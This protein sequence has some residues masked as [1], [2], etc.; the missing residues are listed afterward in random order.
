MKTKYIFGLLIAVTGLLWGVV[1]SLPD[2]KLH[3]Y[4]CDV[5]QGDAIL[6]TLGQTQVLIDGGPNNNVLKCLSDN[7]PFWDRDLELVISTHPELDHLAGLVTVVERYN[8]RQIISNSLIGE[9]GTF[10]KFRQEVII[11][12]IPVY[13]P[14]NGDKIK[15]GKL[16]FRVLFP[17]EKLG[18]EIVWKNPSDFK[19][20][21][22][23][24]F[25]GN[26][27]TTAVV[28]ELD[29]GN[30]K[31]LLTGDIG[32]EEEKEI[33]PD[34]EL[35][36]VLKVAHHGS[37]YSTSREFLEKLKPSLAV[38]S[39][40]VSNRYGH[41]TSEVLDRLKSDGIK[42][43]RTDLSGTIE[44]VSDGKSWYTAN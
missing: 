31:A 43:L 16:V 34:L 40:G 39:V 44:V 24:A 42:V 30:F 22:L 4:F 15:V 5:G 1:S 2:S 32:V 13:S 21:G 23:S 27:N 12:K 14:R 9:T 11:K 29:F 38:I 37:K 10:S 28:T 20:L 26:F 25:S 3:L 7:M 18:D 41:P 33:E 35:V 8:V 6:A 17:L 36:N 19:V